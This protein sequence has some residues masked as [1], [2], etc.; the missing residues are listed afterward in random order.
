MFSRT[1]FISRRTPPVPEAFPK[2]TTAGENQK[3]KDKEGATRLSPYTS[4]PE[5]SRAS[6]T[7]TPTR[8]QLADSVAEASSGF[9]PMNAS[10]TLPEVPAE[11]KARYE[12]LMSSRTMNE[13]PSSYNL[14][15]PQFADSI[16][17][18][19]S[20]STA[21]DASRNLPD[22]SAAVE[23][24]IL[25]QTGARYVESISSRARRDAR[26]H[27]MAGIK[28]HT[29]GRAEPIRSIAAEESRRDETIQ[30]PTGDGATDLE[31]ETLAIK[32]GAMHGEDLEDFLI[33]PM[34]DIEHKDQAMITRVKDLVPYL[35]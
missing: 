25:A 27:Y 28:E 17:E 32:V 5:T 26:A 1:A 3:G 16:A 9:T 31:R 18:G 35:S 24:A 30:S 11:V 23:S 12:A 22:L 21:V 6:E 19:S 20:A 29:P 4:S 10:R 8:P 7:A 15:R 2:S 14:P 33:Y 13:A 34:L